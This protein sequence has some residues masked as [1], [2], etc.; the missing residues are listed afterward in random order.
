MA[1]KLWESLSLRI[2]ADFGNEGDIIRIKNKELQSAK[3]LDDIVSKDSI[4]KDMISKIY[5]G[6]S[7]LAWSL[8]FLE[9]APQNTYERMRNSLEFNQ[10]L[11]KFK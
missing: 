1:H 11:K 5:N 2:I 4:L 3:M 9:N 10:M 8:N 6:K 7:V